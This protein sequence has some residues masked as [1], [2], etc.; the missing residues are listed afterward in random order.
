MQEKVSVVVTTKNEAKNIA[1][2][3]KSIKLQTWSNVEIIVVDNNSND[4]TKEIA[5]EYTELVFDKGPERSAQRNYGLIEIASGKYGMFIDA[6]MILTPNLLEACVEKIESEDL[7]ALHVEEI[8][9]GTGMLAKVRRFERSFYSGTCIDGVRFFRR[10]DFKAINGFDAALPPGPEDWDL[11]QRFLQTGKLGLVGAGTITEWEMSTFISTKG[12]RLIPS[13]AGIF[14]NE[15]EQS[16]RI[17]LSKKAYYSGSMD[18]YKNKWSG[19]P[20][21]NKQLGI[22]YRYLFVFVENEKWK[23]LFKNPVLTVGMYA[24]RFLVGARY[25]FETRS[26]HQ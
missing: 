8:V 21:I 14:H 15:D 17:Y 13:F 25:L 5:R 16:L 19:S 20:V 11:D 18:V 7:I 2:C 4:K 24:L 22:K 26:K 3:L 10:E 9:L 12:V 1:N 23:K 6:D